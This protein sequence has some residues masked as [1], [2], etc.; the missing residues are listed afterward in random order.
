MQGI[1]QLNPLNLIDELFGINE[2]IDWQL[3]R[4]LIALFYVLNFVRNGKM[5]MYECV[6]EKR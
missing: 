3:M 5:E 1:N 2:S 6:V 4:I